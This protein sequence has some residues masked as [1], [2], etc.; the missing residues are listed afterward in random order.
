MSPRVRLTHVLSVTLALGGAVV[1]NSSQAQCAASGGAIEL[2]VVES[3][4]WLDESNAYST[5]SGGV[6]VSRLDN[7]R[8]RGE[9]DVCGMSGVKTTASP[10]S[11]VNPDLHNYEPVTPV[12]IASE[13]A[14]WWH[15]SSSAEHIT[16]IWLDAL[17]MAPTTTE[18]V[19][20]EATTARLPVGTAW[21]PGS[22]RPA[23]TFTLTEEGGPTHGTYPVA[24]T[25]EVQLDPNVILVPVNIHVFRDSSGRVAGRPYEQLH[26]E[27]FRQDIDPSVAYGDHHNSVFDPESGVYSVAHRLTTWT[28]AS[29]SLLA[30]SVWAQCDIQFQVNELITHEQN[31]GLDEV[32]MSGEECE[33]AFGLVCNPHTTSLQRLYSHVRP[34]IASRPDI[35]LNIFVGGDLHEACISNFSFFGLSCGPAEAEGSTCRIAMRPNPAA[36]WV[37]IEAESWASEPAVVPHELGHQ[38]GLSHRDGPCAGSGFTSQNIM[39]RP[40]DIEGASLTPNQCARARCI[41]QQWLGEWGLLSSPPEECPR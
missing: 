27:F 12:L 10:L 5:S 38:L 17:T 1:A 40:F 33:E 41:A 4:P 13:S 25:V 22:I 32:M 20:F 35:G 9:V 21:A 6:V 34:I 19:A 23:V 26:D 8:L 16:G 37:F 24:D 36:H 18:R 31:D 29:R 11:W 39:D 15:G 2:A 30:D 14:L 28:T 3:A 7:P